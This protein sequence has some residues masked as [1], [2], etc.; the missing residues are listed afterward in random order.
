MQYIIF[1][2]STFMKG[3]QLQLKHVVLNKLIQL[4][5]R[6]TDLTHIYFR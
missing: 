6:E 5:L 4:V 1:P 3:S 2:V